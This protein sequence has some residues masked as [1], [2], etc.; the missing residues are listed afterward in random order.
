MS[1]NWQKQPSNFRL[2][3]ALRRNGAL[4]RSPSELFASY[5]ADAQHEAGCT[6]IFCGCSLICMEMWRWY[7]KTHRVT[8]SPS[9]IWLL[10]NQPTRD[11]TRRP[12]SFI[13]PRFGYYFRPNPFAGRPQK[14]TCSCSE[15][16]PDLSGLRDNPAEHNFPQYLE[17]RLCTQNHHISRN[18]SFANTRREGNLSVTLSLVALFVASI[19]KGLFLTSLARS[20]NVLLHGTRMLELPG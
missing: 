16:A 6:G 17:Q 3:T 18:P 7:L 9:I 12:L 13:C 4:S 15:H 20:V 14:G 11:R 19:G 8:C 1:L 10:T 5:R 2:E